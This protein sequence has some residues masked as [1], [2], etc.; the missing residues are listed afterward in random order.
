VVFALEF[1][2]KFLLCVLSCFYEMG[3]EMV[4]TTGYFKLKQ[5]FLSS[6]KL[7]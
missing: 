2:G 6:N 7:F 5:A 4:A 3:L 1:S